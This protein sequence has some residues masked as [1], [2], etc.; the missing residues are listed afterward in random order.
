MKPKSHLHGAEELRAARRQSRGLY[1]FVALFS[2]FANLLM[3]T[4]PLYMLQV[5]DR[6]LGSRSE[7]TLVA[8]SLLVVFLYGVMGILD[9]T[10][11]RV[12]SRA[13][14]RF[15]EALDHR[16]FDA[17]VRRSAVAQDPLAQT[18]LAD[19]ES[20]QRFIA[21]PVAMSIFDLPWTPIFLFAIAI[22]HPWL[23]LLALVGGVLLIA[24]TGI[25]QLVSRKPALHAAIASNQAAKMGEEIRTEAE[26]IQSMGMR[27]AAFGRWRK[28]RVA[29][30]KDGLSA[31]DVLGSFSTLTKTLRLFLQS[32]MLGLGAYLVLQ[33]EVTPGAMI[34][35][36]ILMG[37]ALAPV[38]MIVN[39]W[40]VVQR[41]LKGWSNL[42][43]LLEKVRPENKRMDL[44][45]PK[46][47]LDVQSLTV[48]PPG[49]TRAQLKTVSFTVQPGQAVGVIGPSGSGK[50]TLAR[51][52]TG[53][54]KPAGGTVR[55]DGA[56]IEQYDPDVLGQHIGYLP[57]RVQL[58]E[59][60]IAENIAR[61]SGEPDAKKVVEAAT[62]A[63][64]HDMILQL[65]DGYDTHITAGGGRLSGGQMQRVGLARALYDDPVI[66]ILDEP[67]SNL[68]NE[69]SIAL[70]KAIK[71]L[72]EAGKSV[73][74][75]AHRP[76]AIAECDMLLVLDHGVRTAFGPKDQVLREMVTNHQALKTN[77]TMGGV[78]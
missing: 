60:T 23:G 63:A 77:K 5:Y 9:Y 56:A 69:G 44:P 57:Q 30:L 42:S 78:R 33:G 20:V 24:I 50:S 12:M 16:V 64:V 51:A 70:N 13:G 31:S 49:D 3:L 26:T 18:G 1:W 27:G 19:L 34:A 55:L 37:R 38:E 72:K 52:L 53:V 47:K 48:V 4:G 43:E 68:D 14:A 21:S 39:Q 65:P 67:N 8:L 66:V 76:A 73:L 2:F 36:S 45:K 61:L 7:Q 41:A 75:M 32:A 71:T 40:Q 62:K 28:S 10:R 25:N 46:A 54:W 22:F 6:V 59:G 15:Q 74:I 11:G 58:F 17:M 29:S 35:A